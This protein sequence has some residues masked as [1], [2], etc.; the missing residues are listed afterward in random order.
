M[1]NTAKQASS[2]SCE[3]MPVSL[4]KVEFCYVQ[5]ILDKVQEKIPIDE[6]MRVLE[7][8]CGRGRFSACLEQR[9]RLIATDISLK[10]LRYNPVRKLARMD[11]RKLAFNDQNFDVVFCHFVLHHLSELREAVIEMARVTEKYLVIIEPNRFHYKNFF[12]MIFDPEE[13]QLRKYSMKKIR[14]AAESAGFRLIDSFSIGI[15]PPNVFSE[16]HISWIK[17]MN[18]RQPFGWDQ[19]LLMER[20]ANLEVA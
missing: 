18:F 1:R 3:S 14:T 16:K 8:G 6:G 20:V 7:I 19:V 10:E 15:F 5:A 9:S 4:S 13:R 11:V 12:L 2:E 17:R